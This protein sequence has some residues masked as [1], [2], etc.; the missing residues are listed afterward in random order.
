MQ[1]KIDFHVGRQNDGNQTI[2]QQAE[3][4]AWMFMYA[5]GFDL[6]TTSLNYTIMW[7][8]N[9]ENMVTVF[10]TVSKM[11]NHLIDYV[12]SR[13]S[14]YNQDIDESMGSPI[15]GSHITPEEIAKRLGIEKEF[16]MVKQKEEIKESIRQKFIL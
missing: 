13:I 12:N 7:G 6:K 14:K 11:V 9:P 16:N 10:E 1:G 3:I 5:F 4:S 8:G 2:E 15:H